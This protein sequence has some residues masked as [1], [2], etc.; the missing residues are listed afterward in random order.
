MENNQ[1]HFTSEASEKLDDVSADFDFL[2]C[3]RA[4]KIARDRGRTIVKVDDVTEAA[5]VLFSALRKEEAKM[6]FNTVKEALDY[7]LT[8]EQKHER[9]GIMLEQMVCKAL[10]EELPGDDDEAI[11]AVCGIYQ[12]RVSPSDVRPFIDVK[13]FSVVE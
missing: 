4:E 1:L 12:I 9:A 11:I 10:D 2:L 13:Q 3:G 7:Y 6:E 5:E 8:T